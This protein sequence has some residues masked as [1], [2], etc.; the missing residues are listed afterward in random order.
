MTFAKALRSIL[1]QDPD[2]ILIGE[3][4]DR[5]TADIAIQAALTGHLVLSTLHTN[6]A[7][8]AITRFLDMGVPDYLLAS[9]MLAV[10]AQR[11]VRRLCPVCRRATPIPAHFA[12]RFELPGENQVCEAVGCNRCAHTGFRGRV[13]IGE[14][15]AV[16][17]RVRSAIV[18]HPGIDEL[19]AA[20]AETDPETM[21]DDG[22]RKVLAGIT[23]FEEVIRIAG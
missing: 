8:G 23:T 2:V 6:N 9:S 17:S 18:Q 13:P 3:I 15:K 20:A 16:S 12:E 1:R 14:L 7:V 11:L 5:E 19:E 4:R 21:L 22:I 10:T